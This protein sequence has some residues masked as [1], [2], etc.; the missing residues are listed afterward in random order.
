MNK[1]IFI[2]IF[3]LSFLLYGVENPSIVKNFNGFEKNFG[4]AQKFGKE[5][6]I[7]F[8][9]DNNLGIFLTEKGLN[10]IIY[11]D[12]GYSRIKLELIGSNLKEENIYY[13]EEQPG[14]SNYYLSNFPN[15]ILNV[16]SYK[17]II[18]K[19]IYPNVNWLFKYDKGEIH[20]EFEVGRDA[21]LD[22]IRF[23]VRYAD[24]EIKE[25]GK[26]IVFL[27]PFGKVEEG[28]LIGISGKNKINI[29]YK[30][31][32]NIISFY[33]IGWDRKEKLIID[34]PLK[35]VWSTYY[36]G[37]SFD[38]PITISSDVFGNVF[39][40]GYT[41]S[42]DFPLQDPGG[43][44]YFQDNNL[45]GKIPFILKFTNDGVREWATFYGGHSYNYIYS[46]ATDNSGNLFATGCTWSYDFPTQDAGGGAY[47]Q[48]KRQ[49]FSDAFILKFDNNGL[50][51]WATY[52][53]GDADE[54]G[55]SITTDIFGNIF[56]AGKTSSSDFPTQ[57]P[58]GGAYYNE[59]RGNYD[60]DV[61]IL[62]FT[63]EGKRIWGT[64]YGGNND[65]EAFAITTDK[66]GNLYITGNTL[67]VDFPVKREIEES[68]YQESKKGKIDGFILKFSNSGVWK[69]ATYYGGSLDDTFLSI[70]ADNIGNLFLTGHT[71]SKD[72]PL[73]GGEEGSYF[74]KSIAGAEDSFIL[75]FTNEGVRKWATYYG[76]SNSD[77]GIC[78]AYDN[79]N[80]IYLSGHTESK[81]FP[82]YNP[83]NGNYF[84][85]IFKAGDA[86]IL[87]FTNEGAIEW[88]TYYGG[89]NS[90]F[91]NN[92]LAID[93][94]DNIF[95]TGSSR[96]IDLPIVKAIEDSYCQDY[97]DENEYGDGFIAKFGIPSMREEYRIIIPAVIKIEETN[98]SN[99]K[100][101]IQ[102]FNPT[103]E[104]VN[105]KINFIISG[106][107]EDTTPYRYDG[108]IERNSI[109]IFNDI[110]NEIFGLKQVYGAVLIEANGP[111]IATARTYSQEKVS[112]GQFIKGY[113][114]YNA[115]DGKYF[116]RENEKGHIFFLINSNDFRTNL[117]FMEVKGKEIKLNISIYDDFNNLLGLVSYSLPPFGFLQVNDLF[118]NLGI[119]GIHDKARAEV[120]VEGEGAV[121]AYA[122]VV[123]NSLLS[124]KNF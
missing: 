115:L 93:K 75:K 54:C 5:K 8:I 41:F 59:G 102:L 100:T 45:S 36:G 26:K 28:E 47:Y 30:R 116:I 96:S 101:D 14:Y 81:D 77:F 109:L 91:G 123:D 86:F 124:D 92:C 40:A 73:K 44:S 6:V 83:N 63:N 70:T 74:Q 66:L 38:Y 87:E 7:F 34:P 61:F 32:K 76:G 13:E 49:G 97:N 72:F 52:Y 113:Y 19:E 90:D 121:F 50:R 33:A 9:R 114:L 31:S 98:S 35:L 78:I 53:G 95:L 71:W 122:S 103:N 22:K 42:M 46:L 64:Y 111:I 119:N 104:I 10:Y 107:D 16:K 11:G 39:V 112:Y 51:K 58:G 23:K 120:E 84:Q 80:N 108:I 94:F 85:E 12:N 68:Y 118:N 57:D 25:N 106:I 65:D 4:Q 110:V 29:S 27:A 105:Y 60:Y 88:A 43:G 20:Q 67:S 3:Y 56:V 79:S 24:L 1:I 82:I 69:W 37:S 117:G 18:I 2:L 55:N 17:K 15:G 21:S 99:W 89:S 62:K 48:D